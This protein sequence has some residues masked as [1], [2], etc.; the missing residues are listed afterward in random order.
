MFRNKSLFGYSAQEE[1]HKILFSVGTDGTKASL[2]QRG[3]YSYLKRNQLKC[4]D[5]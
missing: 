4:E 1:C 2:M 5:I 3:V